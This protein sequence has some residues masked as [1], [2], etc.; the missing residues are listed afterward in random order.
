MEQESASSARASVTEDLIEINTEKEKSIGA[1]KHVL[2]KT[3]M[4]LLALLIICD[5][6]S[7]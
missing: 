3:L 2:L 5:I 1:Q 7:A 6:L 4:L